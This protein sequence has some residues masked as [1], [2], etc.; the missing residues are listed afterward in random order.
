MNTYIALL[1]GINVGGHKKIPMAELRLLLEKKGLR[2]VKT[3][4]QSGNVVFQSPSQDK[5]EI[6]E[7]I[8]KLILDHFGFEV[9]V[10]VKT[11]SELKTIINA[12]P[13]LEDE[14]IKSYFFLLQSLPNKENVEEASEKQY[15][16]EDYKI[17]NDCIYYY[18]NK[19][20]GQAKFNMSL[21]ERKLET[22]A[23]SRNYRTMVKLI[24]M[25]ATQ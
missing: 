3:Y 21:F 12:C 7:L 13:F 22:N 17:L 5:T 6:E 10:L 16:G 8:K 11:H 1:R 25:S 9:P 19:G 2:N 4:I 15:E 20:Y 24:E 23:T 14:K 18:C